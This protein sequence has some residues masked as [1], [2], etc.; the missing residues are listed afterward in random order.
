MVFQKA[1]QVVCSL[2]DPRKH[3]VVSAVNLVDGGTLEII[4]QCLK[5]A[6]RLPG[7]RVTALVNRAAL[8]DI[9]GIDYIERP[10]VK[11]S[12][13]K[14]LWFEY[15]EC[16]GLAERLRPDFW[17]SL[18]DMTPNLGRLSGKV[19]Q[20]VY[21]HNALV[22][23]PL[24]VREMYLEPV[25]AIFKLAYPWAYR[26]YI[27]RNSAVVV[28]QSWIR[29]EF[30][31]RFGCRHVVVAHPA[32][33]KTETSARV[34]RGA[35]FF[36]PAYPRAFKNF[37]V[38]LRAWEILSGDPAWSGE[39]SIT[40]AAGGNRYSR[41]LMTRFGHLRNVKFLGRLAP[42]QVS[43]IYQQSDCLVFPSKLETWGLPITEAKQSGLF[44]LAAD[45]PYARETVG[46]YDGAAFFNPNDAAQLADLIRR[47]AQGRLTPAGHSYQAIAQPFAT[48]WSQL[49]RLLL[50]PIAAPQRR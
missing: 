14:R 24:S 1:R 28:Q 19:P 44:V 35:R 27:Q 30:Q 45:L 11:P 16:A 26:A 39:L 3:L 33:G 22:F 32:V 40:I 7:W 29:D 25:L 43:D 20:A 21:C 41:H 34:T 49:L 38:L 9:D 31:R 47:F 2:N 46:S 6:A 13:L 23:Y 15:V 4:R 8:F 36:Y 12:W 37:E 10:D 17:L 42:S 50:E 18:H 48:D 5:E